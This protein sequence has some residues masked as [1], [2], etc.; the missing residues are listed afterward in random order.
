MIKIMGSKQIRAEKQGL[1]LDLLALIANLLA[2]V[3]LI[4]ENRGD[5][6]IDVRELC[7]ENSLLLKVYDFV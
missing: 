2:T 5:K 3:R 7:D 6:D 4:I 1:I